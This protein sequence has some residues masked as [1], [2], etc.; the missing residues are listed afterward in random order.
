[1]KNKKLAVIKY[2]RNYISSK[3]LFPKKSH[4]EVIT[5][6]LKRKSVA[7]TIQA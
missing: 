2:N 3:F 5:L 4:H 1:M 6:L 7:N